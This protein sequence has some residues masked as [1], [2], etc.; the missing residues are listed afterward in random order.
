[1]RNAVMR[2]QSATVAQESIARSL[3]S[4]TLWLVVV[5]CAG[6]CCR[7]A[8]ADG[9][10]WRL[11]PGEVLR[12]TMEEKMTSTV[13]MGEREL[14]SNTSR[15]VNL[16]WNV[17]KVSE[18]GDAEIALRF[19]RVRM[20]IEQ[21][22]YMPYDLDSSAPKVDAPEPFG[23]MAQQLKAMAG[24]EFQFKLKPS[25]AIED[26]KVPDYT[27]KALRSG[28]PEQAQGTFT[29]QA[30]KDVFMQSSPPPFPDEATDPGK[31][32][33]AKPSKIPTPL[34]NL[35]VEKTFTVLGADPKNSNLLL[36]GTDAKV[37][38]E[39]QQNTQ[40]STT[41][42]SQEGK[43]SI[44]FDTAAGRIVNSRLTQKMEVAIANPTNPGQTTIQQSE[45]TS[46][47]AI[48]P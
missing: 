3:W 34:G 30:L 8:R 25:G 37:N 11:K 39:P 42:R 35:V 12:Y 48:E 36:I 24:A 26:F 2:G 20:H 44:A 22:P 19:D 15:T 43:G 10:R 29:E 38:V 21:P 31:S 32:W 23:S 17:Q 1:M 5:A 46:T 41:I 40:V 7:D 45:S 28:L 4:V 47:M 18:S 27:L 14:K 9:L 6:S 13:K 33:M 16:S